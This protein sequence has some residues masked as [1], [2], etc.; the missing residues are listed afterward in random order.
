M[1][2]LDTSYLLDY[3]DGVEAARAYLADNRDAPF[4]APGLSL[5]E[6]YSGAARSGGHE[7]LSRAADSLEW[8]EPLPLTDAAAREAAMVEAEL[9]DDG[10]RINLGDVLIAGICRHQGRGLR[11]GRRTRRDPVLNGRRVGRLPG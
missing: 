2:A 7:A 1:I 8:V 4:H 6:V 5:F 3:L 10:E 11:A 9:L